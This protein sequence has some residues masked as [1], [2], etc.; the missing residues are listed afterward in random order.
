M[1]R[2]DFPSQFSW[3]LFQNPYFSKRLC[4]ERLALT[5]TSSLGLG[6]L[7]FIVT[8]CASTQDLRKLET[9]T[10]HQLKETQQH[11]EQQRSRHSQDMQVVKQEVQEVRQDLRQLTAQHQTQLWEVQSQVK[12]GLKRLDQQVD[13]LEKVWREL[14]NVRTDV[15]LLK[16]LGIALDKVQERLETAHGVLKALKAETAAQRE[17]VSTLEGNVQDIQALQEYLQS[18]TERLRAVVGEIGEEI[19]Q[20]LNLEMNYA[21]DRL[22]Q[23]EQVLDRLPVGENAGKSKAIHV[24]P[25][26]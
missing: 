8:G 5:S 1:T 4:R 11:I 22:H 21:R 15:S 7:L 16:P 13:A 14:E 20:R 6:V 9:Q 18:A 26:G 19:V 24:A 2:R 25:P 17:T 12:S 3:L 23:L 10:A